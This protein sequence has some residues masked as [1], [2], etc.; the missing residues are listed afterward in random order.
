[1]N[2][3]ILTIDWNLLGSISYRT[4]LGKSLKNTLR[5]FDKDDL[6]DELNAMIAFFTEKA[7]DDVIRHENRIKSLQSCKLKYQKFFPNK[8]VE[9]AFNDILGLRIVLDN[10]SVF[11]R[12][13]LPEFVKV[14]DMRDG[15]SEDDGYRGIHVYY[16]KDHFH[17]PIEVQFVTAEDRQFNEWLHIYVYKYITDSSV[18]SKLRRM[19]EDGLIKNE[20]QFR[21]E[22]QKCVT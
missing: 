7:T 19:Y 16:Q 20:S 1:M 17:Y 18:G 2:D 21:E 6:F 11:D 12:L 13:K 22:I 9:K 10:Y 3:A 4:E 14:A 5:K 8:Q 15:K